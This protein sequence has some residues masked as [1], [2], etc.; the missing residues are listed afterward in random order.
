[1]QKSGE[2]FYFIILLNF[3]FLTFFGEFVNYVEDKR[4]EKSV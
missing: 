4:D 1:M 3:L 2:F